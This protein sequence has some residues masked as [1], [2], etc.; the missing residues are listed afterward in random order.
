MKKNSLIL[1]M[2]LLLVVSFFG[3]C[4]KEAKPEKYQYTFMDAFDTASTIMGYAENEDV[5]NNAAKA[6]HDELLEYHR[7]FDIYND[8]EGI[9][10]LKT[11]NDMAGVA[12]VEVDERIIDFL[13]FCK[14]VEDATGGKVNVAMG[15]VL[16]IWH[17]AREAASEDPQ[18]AAVPDMTRLEIAS[19]HD[20]IDLLV[21][22]ED[23]CT[24]YI[25]D[26]EMSLDVGALAKGYALERVADIVPEGYLVNLGGNVKAFGAKPDGSF[27]TVGIRD[28]KGSEGSYSCVVKTDSCSVVTSGDYQRYY[29]AEG[30]R[31]HHIIN[32]DTLLPSIYWSSVSI[33]CEDSSMADALSTALFVLPQDEGEAL[34]AEFAAEALWVSTDGA[35]YRS[36]GFSE[37]Q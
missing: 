5:F 27:W 15:S 16:S 1:L 34:L 3:G 31:W 21:I 22:D 13:I 10:N 29:E 19:L 35:E 9:N 4:A 33:I 6:I 36:S 37:Y 17:D 2:A 26:P 18:S 30:R 11:V 24:V 25:Q 23:V 7:L 20:D 14:E 12:P 32:P 28:P 8:Y